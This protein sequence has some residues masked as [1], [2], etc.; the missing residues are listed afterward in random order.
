MIAIL[1]VILIVMLIVM[2]HMV[3]MLIVSINFGID[4]DPILPM[5]PLN[6]PHLLEFTAI[7]TNINNI[8]LQLPSQQIIRNPRGIHQNMLINTKY[9]FIRLSIQI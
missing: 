1:V 5:F 3:H 6:K 8:S 4:Q 7:M 2:A 9:L